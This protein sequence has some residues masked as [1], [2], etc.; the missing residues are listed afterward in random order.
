[1]IK[2]FRKIRHFSLREGKLT[3]YLAYAIGEIILIVIGIL[4][5]LQFNTFHQNSLNKKNEYYYLSQ[6]QNDLIS[7][8]LFLSQIA[9][10][11]E[12]RLPVIQALL[13]ELHKENNQESFNKVFREYVNTILFLYISCPIRLHTTKWNLVLSWGL[14]AIKNLEIK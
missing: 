14:Y 2:L 4:I 5:A 9:E 12:N 10:D 6:M 3:N 7:D 13:E 11:L 1:M 8:S